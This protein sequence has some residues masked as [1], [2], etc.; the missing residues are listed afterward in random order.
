MATLGVGAE[1]RALAARI[2]AANRELDHERTVPDRTRDLVGELVA[3]ITDGALAPAGTDPQLL[4]ELARGALRASWALELPNA[5]ARRRELRLGLEQ[6]R[7]VLVE[8]G[9]EEPVSDARPAKEV[10]RWLAQATDLPQ[11]R[12]AALVGV[13]ERTFQR[14]VS[15]TDATAPE[16]DDARRLRIVARI[17]AQLRHA[18]TGGGV[19][20]WF[21]RPRADL[22]GARPAELLDDPDRTMELLGLAAGMRDSSAA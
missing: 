12:L 11:R 3:P 1:A 16:G 8:I 4:W 22:G 19:V 14:W 15:A 7:Q 10:A 9:E 13:G 6:M 20:A 5:A 17:V 21:E 2:G 18:L